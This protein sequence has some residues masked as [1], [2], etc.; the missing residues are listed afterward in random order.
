MDYW[1]ETVY[2]TNLRVWEY[3]EAFKTYLKK[4]GAYVIDMETATIFSVGFYNRRL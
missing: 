4:I 3:D 1:T 2:T